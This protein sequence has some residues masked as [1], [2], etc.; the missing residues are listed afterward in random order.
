MDLKDDN[1]LQLEKN[2]IANIERFVVRIRMVSHQIIQFHLKDETKTHS[3]D[4]TTSLKLGVIS[5]N[6]DPDEDGFIF[7]VK[8]AYAI[9][10]NMN[11]LYFVR[12]NLGIH[13]NHKGKQF[14]QGVEKL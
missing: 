10:N 2:L 14:E 3:E 4:I 9:H 6:F 5:S 1:A 7:G 8:E 11:I 13:G 12:K